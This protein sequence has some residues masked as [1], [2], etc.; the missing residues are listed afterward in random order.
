MGQVGIRDS[1]V[2]MGTRYGNYTRLYLTTIS[3][4]YIS[5]NTPDF[6][7]DTWHHMVFR[8]KANLFSVYVDGDPEASK[9]QAAGDNTMQ[10]EIGGAARYSE[11]FN[12][13]MS[14]AAIWA[15]A[16]SETRIQ[17]LA[18]GIPVMAQT[19]ATGAILLV[20]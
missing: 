14:D 13:Y 16:L 1:G 18:D 12:G 6:N 10:L 20:R 8:R 15:E 2:L 11:D 5:F 4:S 3:G 7:D 9:T 19:R 17:Q